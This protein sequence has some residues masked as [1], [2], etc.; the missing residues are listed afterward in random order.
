ML[1]M[2]VALVSEES[3]IQAGELS[4]VAAALQKQITRDFAPIWGVTGDV[5][6]FAAL[7][8]VPLDYWPVIIRDDIGED[9]EGVHLDNQGQPYALVKYDA[10]WTLTASHETLEMLADPFGKRL[11]AGDSL[12]AQQGRVQYLVEVC[13]PC[14][15]PN[16]AYSI[17]GVTVSDF[18][19]PHFFD[20]V[21]AAGV[22][23]SFGGSLSG[24][25]DVARGGYLSWFV[26]AL[27]Q[28]WQRNWLGDEP[29]DGQIEGLVI[30]GDH[31]RGA[32]DRKT[33]KFRRQLGAVA[34]ARKAGARRAPREPFA[35]RGL[36]LRHAMREA[37]AV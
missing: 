10:G 1:A 23:Y 13:D 19:T 3:G 32:I 22:R 6:A 31:F 4:E 5:A 7:E 37:M 28:W 12:V 25:R 33:S 11:V 2:H 30:S 17:N 26:P 34:W 35:A 14:E 24:P 21:T 8:Q 27:G 20:P 16:F 18:Y 15:A 9:A 29:T 36:M